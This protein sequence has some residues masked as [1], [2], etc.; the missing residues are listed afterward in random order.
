[1]TS[2]RRTTLKKYLIVIA[3]VAAFTAFA[4]CLLSTSAEAAE[5][6]GITVTERVD[7]GECPDCEALLERVDVLTI[8]VER[9]HFNQIA[10][11]EVADRLLEL[12]VIV[13]DFGMQER[14]ECEQ[15]QPW[16]FYLFWVALILKVG[17]LIGAWAAKRDRKRFTTNVG[18][19]SVHPEPPTGPP[20]IS[21][22]ASPPP[23]AGSPRT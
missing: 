15:E 12:E 13:S 1:M 23:P 9:I 7:I 8:L 14:E 21:A 2:S 5:P 10:E 17:V 16:Y 19:G 20:T 6:E 18:C 22:P 3:V 4:A 11:C